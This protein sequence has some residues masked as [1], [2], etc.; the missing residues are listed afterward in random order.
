MEGDQAYREPRP[1]RSPAERTSWGGRDETYRSGDRPERERDS[2]YRGRS[3]GTLVHL[4]CDTCIFVQ[5]STKL[6]MADAAL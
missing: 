6:L 5:A 3:P 2:F 4:Q 1:A